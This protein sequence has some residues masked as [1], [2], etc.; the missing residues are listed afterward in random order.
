MKYAE[1]NCDIIYY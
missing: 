1:Y